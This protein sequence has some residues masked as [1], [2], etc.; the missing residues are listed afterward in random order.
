MPTTAPHRPCAPARRVNGPCA[1]ARRAKG[2][3]RDSQAGFTLI[4]LT[5]VVLIA[6]LLVR[7]AIANLGALI[8]T[9]KMDSVASQLAAW[10]AERRSEAVLSGKSLK[11][12]I[13]L[14]RD[15]HCEVNPPEDQ[16]LSTAPVE[17]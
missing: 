5:L 16:Y 7:I 8:P 14:D 6:A 17:S 12:L 13:D 1:P 9:S 11:F 15:M 10:L 2:Q 4:E 3:Q